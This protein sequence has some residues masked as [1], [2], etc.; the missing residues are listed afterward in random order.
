[1]TFVIGTHWIART[2]EHVWK[3]EDIM[4]ELEVGDRVMAFDEL[5]GSEPDWDPVPEG[6][7][8]VITELDWDGVLVRFETGQRRKVFTE[9]IAHE[10]QKY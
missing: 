5:D 6:T 1:M 2:R 10:I 8:G 9:K 4:D 3:Q 7:S